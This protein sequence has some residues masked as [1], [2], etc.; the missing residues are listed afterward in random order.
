MSA[1]GAG[2]LDSLVDEHDYFAALTRGSRA[3]RSFHPA[4]LAVVRGA[5]DLTGKRILDVGA[6]TGPLAIPLAR[7]GHDVTA[8][9]LSLAHGRALKGYAGDLIVPVVQADAGAL[10]FSDESFD[11]VILAS[12]VHLLEAPGPVLREAERVCRR[13]GRLVIAGPWGRHPKSNRLLKT[14]LRGGKAPDGRSFP[15]T[16]RRLE[17]LLPRSRYLGRRMN[18]L[19]GYFATVWVPERR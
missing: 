15:F 1:H 7:E 8:V 9:E 19:L 4:R 3:E 18:R 16:V 14:I 6:S 12:L 17:R 2:R 11:V 10:P 13:D 5:V